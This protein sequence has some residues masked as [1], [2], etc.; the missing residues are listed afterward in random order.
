VVNSEHTPVERD[1]QNNRAVLPLR[2]FPDQTPPQIEI[3]N[4]GRTIRNG[5]ALENKPVIDIQVSDQPGFGWLRDTQLLEVYL[6]RPTRSEW[7]RL[8]FQQDLLFVPA[9]SGSGKN[10]AKALWQPLLPAY[11]T[12]SLL[13][14]AWDVQGNAATDVAI[15]FDVLPRRQ[16]LQ[17]E[18]YPN[19]SGGTVCFQYALAGEQPP[20]RYVVRIFNIS[21]QLVRLLTEHDLGPLHIGTHPSDLCWDGTD[22]GGKPLPGGL[23]VGQL[24]LAEEWSETQNPY[25][26]KIVLTH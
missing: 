16:V 8:S 14:K 2:I 10:E 21:G 5:D 3:D 1:Y 4:Q 15:H 22:Q 18:A 23:Y 24:M 12:Y 20:Q 26:F 19:P 6:R 7:Q 13:V 25:S 11:G 9:D 17:W